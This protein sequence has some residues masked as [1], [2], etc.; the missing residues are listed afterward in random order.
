MVIAGR[1]FPVVEMDMDD[2]MDS[3]RK[4]R[5]FGL[6]LRAL[7][8][9]KKANDENRVRKAIESGMEACDAFHTYGVM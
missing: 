5:P 6:I 1:A 9:L 3:K 8:D 7:D 2:T 4:Y